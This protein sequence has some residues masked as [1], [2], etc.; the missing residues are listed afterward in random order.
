MGCKKHKKPRLWRVFFFSLNLNSGEGLVA[1]GE[2]DC[3]LGAAEPISKDDGRELRGWRATPPHPTP[4]A[5]LVARGGRE[6]HLKESIPDVW[7][8]RG[9]DMWQKNGVFDNTNEKKTVGVWGFGGGVREWGLGVGFGGGVW[10]RGLGVGF[11][12]RV[13]GWV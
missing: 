8:K 4:A 7:Q 13:W 1:R 11:G 9:R 5:T 12:G 3:E 2:R 6:H 10:E